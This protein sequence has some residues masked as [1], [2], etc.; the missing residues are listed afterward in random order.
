MSSVEP[1]TATP[2]RH[3][4]RGAALLIVLAILVLVAT[5]I[6]LDRLNAAAI[7]A[8]NRDP[9]SMASLAS[10][11]DA[12]IA[13]AATHPDTPGLLPFPDR[14]D[15]GTPNYDGEADC[16]A[17]GVIAAT[18]L[19][20]RFPIRGEQAGC[21]TNIELS[22]ET[23]DSSRER[24]WYAVSRNLVRGGGGGPV[25]PDIGELGIHPWITVRDQSGTVINDRV[26]AVIIA[27]GP[28]I[29]AQDRGGVAPAVGNFLDSVTVGP[30]TFSNSDAD[31]C[32]DD[33]AAC[34]PASG[35]DFFVFPGN[36]DGYNDRLMFITVDELMRAVEDRV[37]GEAARALDFY[38]GGGDIYPWLAPFTDP[39]AKSRGVATGGNATTLTDATANFVGDGVVVGDL[40]RNLT[41]GSARTVSA[42]AATSLTL[43]SQGL[44]GGATNTF[45][46]GDD[47][48]VH[49]VAKFDGVA[50]TLEG[51][52]PISFPGRLF[53]TGFDVTWNFSGEKNSDVF[54]DG[55]PAL[56]P[57]VADVD[58]FNGDTLTI[59]AASGWCKWTT[60]DRVDCMGNTTFA[61][62]RIDNGLPVTRTVEV[63]FN[64]DADTTTITDP[65]FADVRRRSHTYNGPNNGPPTP[66]V[67]PDIPQQ[68]WSVHV[69]DTDGS[70]VGWRRAE[71]DAS[72]D[73]VIN[74]TGIRYEQL[75]AQVADYDLP[76]WFV[77]N[78]WHHFV[79]AALS[80]AHAPQL[81]G[82]STGDG[83]C[84]PPPVS[85]QDDCLTIQ[86]DTA[87]TP[88]TVR[89]DVEALVI[90]SG[91]VLVAQDRDAPIPA[92][93]PPHADVFC[94]YYESP[95]VD[96]DLIFGRQL[97]N[98]FE[99]DTAFN[100]QIRVVS[101]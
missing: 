16:V 47:Y 62:V 66:L 84:S 48:V 99:V 19:L 95:N 101:P 89:S 97:W 8:P 81:G 11:K 39:R 61:H 29:G 2:E 68:A 44:A 55:N 75:D 83:A 58:N 35:E 33:D 10:A 27:P 20:G 79:H 96:A 9:E 13:W 6:L 40:V 4:Q 64:F 54:D 1:A 51:S 65:T 82:T 15:D 69:E 24:L 7:P 53:Q 43:F 72:T 23:V 22:Q 30:D 90:G 59:P 37:L 91:S 80:G 14:N 50:G 92:S 21:V 78:N 31:G 98:T 76:P 25:N 100:D 60:T 34:V 70:N 73:L 88:S 3:R 28:A 42:V 71:R 41:D 85:A 56:V 93:C 38:R 26:A 63:W 45:A 17:P 52:L 74:I 46:A 87:G 49:K 67:A 94:D 32:L 77:D 5:A 86:Y 57:T 12:L 36:T 18:H